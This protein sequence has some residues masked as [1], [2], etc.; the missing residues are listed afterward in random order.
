MLRGINKLTHSQIHIVCVSLDQSWSLLCYGEVE[1]K[2]G[3]TSSNR[4]LAG[5]GVS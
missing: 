4:A 3:V 2:T 1:E 5:T